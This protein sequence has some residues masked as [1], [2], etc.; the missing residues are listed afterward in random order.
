MTAA[1][2]KR[3]AEVAKEKGGTDPSF[4]AVP[5]NTLSL[6][7]CDTKATNG[8]P[9]P[10]EI[11]TRYVNCPKPPNANPAFSYQV[12]TYLCTPNAQAVIDDDNSL[13]LDDK[14][15]V[16]TIEKLCKDRWGAGSPYTLDGT[17]YKIS[18]PKA[19]A[20]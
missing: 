8:C 5:I 19:V 7:V 20:K 16:A 9:A 17:I 1:I 15:N 3:C 6:E 13:Y 18:P 12:P 10:N 4:E 14:D 11:V 2:A